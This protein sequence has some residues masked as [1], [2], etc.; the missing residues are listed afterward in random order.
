MTFKKGS[1]YRRTWGPANRIE[2]LL[3]LDK[4]SENVWTIVQWRQGIPEENE[5][6]WVGPITYQFPESFFRDLNNII[7]IKA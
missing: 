6:E 3:F 4:G 1:L 2:Y 5:D 7:E